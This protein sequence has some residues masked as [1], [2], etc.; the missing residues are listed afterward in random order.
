[1]IFTLI[2]IGALGFWGTPERVASEAAENFVRESKAGKTIMLT[3]V[4]GTQVPHKSGGLEM[5]AEVHEGFLVHWV[6]S[7]KVRSLWGPEGPDSGVVEETL[8]VYPVWVEGECKTS[9]VVWED[10]MK[11]AFQMHP[12]YCQWA[13]LR[14]RVTQNGP[15]DIVMIRSSGG[16][17]A[18]EG[19]TTPMP[20]DSPR[21]TAV[22][23]IRGDDGEIFVSLDGWNVI[24]YLSFVKKYVD[25]RR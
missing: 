15:A 2:I 13:T 6:A 20:K 14:A 16:G 18:A 11:A 19:Y 4:D 9:V 21:E 25:E 5:N 10:G 24:P 23:L 22:F 7:E 8:N 3:L 1:M 17:L 12:L